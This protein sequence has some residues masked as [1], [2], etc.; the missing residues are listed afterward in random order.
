MATRRR[1]RGRRKQKRGF[2]TWSVGAKIAAILGGT[3][4]L[5]MTCGIV[6]VAQKLGKIDYQKVDPKKLSISEEVEHQ[7]G[8]VTFALFGLDSRTGQLGKGT[9]SDSIMVATLN[10]ETKEVRISSIY[11]D[12]L[13]ELE[14]GSYN[15]ANS[16]YAFDGPQ[17]AIAM[18]N[19]NLDLNIQDYVSVNFN[20][21]VNV[22]DALGGIEIDVTEAEVPHL[23]NYAVETSKVVGQERV[24]LEHGGL[25]N[26]SGVQAVSYARIRI[27]GGD[28][29]RAE[30]Q[31]RVLE[32][33]AA[34]AQTAS[35]STINKIIDEVF[36]QVSTSLSLTEML[37]Y[38]KDAFKYK[39]GASGGFPYDQYYNRLSSIGDVGVV[40]DLQADVV[41]L[42]EFLYGDTDYQPS[43][44]V[45]EIGA[46]ITNRGQAKKTGNSVSSSSN[47]W[48]D[49]NDYNSWESSDTDNSWSD[50]GNTSW[51]DNDE[52]D[53]DDT[54]AGNDDTG[55]GSGSSG[56]SGNDNTGEDTSGGEDSGSSEEE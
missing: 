18:L 8:Y 46:E 19:K 22:I 41:Q 26:L 43:Q 16:A 13:V 30:R 28:T 3:F 4:L 35:L 31:R 55:T 7:T 37:D 42:H 29:M 23:N 9:L 44:T 1:R 20:A 11:R 54:G 32:T 53:S 27:I 45:K 47:S 14:D 6:I 39:I 51:G 15:K 2:A 49:N 40:N 33:I 12:T 21:L 52:S 50:D 36:P 48:K 34:K 10:R 56:D 17:G 24:P 5:F 38:A 25:Q